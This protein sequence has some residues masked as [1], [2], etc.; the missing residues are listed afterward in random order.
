[1][2]NLFEFARKYEVSIS[3][4]YIEQHNQFRVILTKGD[5]HRMVIIREIDYCQSKRDGFELVEMIMNDGLVR[6][7]SDFENDKCHK[8]RYPNNIF[9]AFLSKPIQED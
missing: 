7:L 9:S 2:F 3:I 1:M 4:E 8:Q 6:L 5:H